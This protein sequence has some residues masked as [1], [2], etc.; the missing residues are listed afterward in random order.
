[1]NFEIYTLNSEPD[2]APE[3]NIITNDCVKVLR[4]ELSPGSTGI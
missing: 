2:P 4:T 1:M 3:T